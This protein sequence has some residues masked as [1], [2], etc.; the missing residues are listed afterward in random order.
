MSVYTMFLMLGGMLLPY[1][2]GVVWLDEPLSVFRIIGVILL[3][4]S[5]ALPCIS[6]FKSAKALFLILCGIVFVMNGF[7]SITSK[8]H[9]IEQTY[10]VVEAGGFVVLTNLFN[11]IL[12]AIVLTVICI[13]TGSKPELKGGRMT[14]LPVIVV[15]AALLSGG[16]YMLQLIGASNLPASVL[17]PM[18]TGGSM[19][20]TAVAARVFYKEKP[21]KLSLIGLILAFFATLLFLF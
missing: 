9:Q 18:I 2:F 21:D 1:L 16:S 19:V 17:Y 11:G 5:L 3:I 8:I 6:E 10:A 7:V 13:T 15:S 20:L 12:S 4:V 14:L